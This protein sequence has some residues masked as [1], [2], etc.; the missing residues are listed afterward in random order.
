MDDPYETGVAKGGLVSARAYMAGAI[1]TLNQALD[2]RRKTKVGGN[3]S[4]PN[5]QIRLQVLAGASAAKSGRWTYLITRPDQAPRLCRRRMRLEIPPRQLAFPGLHLHVVA[6][7]PT[8]EQ[9]QAV[10]LHRSIERCC[11]SAEVTPL[12]AVSGHLRAIDR[13]KRSSAV[14]CGGAS[15][16]LTVRTRANDA[17]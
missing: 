6:H 12:Q 1:D 14:A 10:H 17:A 5:H 8:M 13:D 15:R 9:A 7:H 4:A 3:A 2:D 11:S 16:G